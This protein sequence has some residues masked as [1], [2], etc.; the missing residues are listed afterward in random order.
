MVEAY[1]IFKFFY[2]RNYIENTIKF[3]D[4]F[5]ITYY[6]Y[7]S[8]IIDIDLSKQFIYNKTIPIFYHKNTG[9]GID[10]KS[11]FYFMFYNMSEAFE[12]M[13]IKTS[14]TDCFLKED[15]KKTFSFYL[16]NN[17]S[18]RVHIDTEYMPNLKLLELLEEG[19]KPVVYNIFE[20]LRFVWIRCYTD[21]ENAINDM[22]W[23]D[24]DYLII[25]VVK[26]WYEKI[27]EILHNEGNF[28]LNGARIIQ[29]TLFIIVIVVFILCY[30]IVWKSYEES[31]TL[32]L[33]KSFDLIKL[34]PEEIKYI[35][36]SKLNE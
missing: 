29:I 21:K 36:V 11:P 33:E 28:F 8:I 17:F 32:L 6:S 23:C 5:N 1:I 7:V 15:Y 16:Y 25:Y 9:L 18:D 35:I 27:I 14:E 31:L 12:K 2:S 10:E 24:I 19:F 13:I 34:I 20:K 3:L 4:V 26:P 22:R 30:F